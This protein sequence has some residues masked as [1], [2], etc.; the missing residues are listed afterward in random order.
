[1]NTPGRLILDA[2]VRQQLWLCSLASSC[3]LVTSQAEG[4]VRDRIRISDA[5]SRLL[6]RAT[7]TSARTWLDADSQYQVALLRGEPVEQAGD[8]P[9]WMRQ[10]NLT[11]RADVTEEDTIKCRLTGSISNALDWWLPQHQVLTLDALGEALAPLIQKINESA[12]FNELSARPPLLLSTKL[13]TK[14]LRSR[15]YHSRRERHNMVLKRVWRYNPSRFDRSP[16]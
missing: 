10:S 14:Y 2:A 5:L 12:A 7:R 6:E 15:G 1:M 13:L 8:I 16:L 9:D 4:L 3:G 11:D